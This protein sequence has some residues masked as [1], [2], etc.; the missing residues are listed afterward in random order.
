MELVFKKLLEVKILHD[1]YL[2][3]LDEKKFSVWPSNYNIL[4]DIEIIPTVECARLL[5]DHQIVFKP[6]PRGFSLYIRVTKSDLS[7]NEFRTFIYLSSDVKLTFL[8]RI[9]NSFFSNYTNLRLTGEGNYLYYFSNLSDNVISNIPFLTKPLMDFP[10]LPD[11][12]S[13]YQYGDMI[14]K[15]GKIREAKQLI[16]PTP[17]FKPNKWVTNDAGDATYLNIQDRI[18]W[19]LPDFTYTRTNENPGETMSF[20]LVDIF[21]NEIQLGNIP[22]TNVSQATY[23]APD[24]A[25]HPVHRKLNFN[26]IKPGKYT[27]KIARVS[28]EPD[29]NFYLLDPMLYRD[30]FGVI[31]LFTDLPVQEFK[32]LVYKENNTTKE[33]IIREKSYHIRF[34]NRLTRW[35]YIKPDGTEI[36]VDEPRGLNIHPSEYRHNGNEIILPDP[37]INL[38][39]PVRSDTDQDLIENI[40][41]EIYLNDQFKIN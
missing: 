23:K 36:L 20:K 7:D 31:E 26:G 1:Y 14:R 18:T 17:P 3:G 11:G 29:L 38:I 39:D 41:S 30:I 28:T 27:L 22:N 5:N 35:K 9:K 40:F 2:K 4:Y 8:I 6:G 19:Q 33:S 25:S 21:D 37:D 10:F 12:E 16:E 24:N 34:K 15:G 32:C 13:K